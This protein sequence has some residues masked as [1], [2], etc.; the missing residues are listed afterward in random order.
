MTGFVGPYFLLERLGE[1]DAGPVFKARHPK[2]DRLVALRIVRQ[3]LL[4]DAD[5]INRFYR[6]TQVLSHLDH[7]NIVRAYDAGPVPPAEGQY[8]VGGNPPAASH[9][10]AEEFV[11][12]TDLERRVRTD[13]PLPVLLACAYVRQAALGLQH[14]YERGLVHGRIKP[15]NLIVDRDEGIIKVAGLGL[16]QL[17]LPGTNAATSGTAG[18]QAP[19]LALRPADI[20][21]DIYSLGCVLHYLLTGQPPFPDSSLTQGPAEAPLL[22]RWPA[23]APPG[24]AAVAAKMLA[25]RPEDR[26]QIPQ[27]VAD[28]LAEF[29]EP[30]RGLVIVPSA[31]E[32]APVSWQWLL[33]VVLGG[34]FL[35]G[36]SLLYFHRGPAGTGEPSPAERSRPRQ[37]IVFWDDLQH[38]R[39]PPTERDRLPAEVVAVLSHKD[40]PEVTGMAISPSG[41]RLAT[42]ARNTITFWEP[43]TANHWSIQASR[44]VHD[45][46]FAPDGLTLATLQV[47]EEKA[48]VVLYD[49]ASRQEQ[50]T[51]AET[52]PCRFEESLPLEYSPDGAVLVTGGIDGKVTVWDATTGTVR[53]RLAGHSAA[54]RALTFTVDGATL[55]SGSSDHTIK[56]KNLK[57]PNDRR[58]ITTSAEAVAVATSIDGRLAYALNDSTIRFWNVV[59]GKEPLVLSEP[60]VASIVF[61]ADGKRLASLSLQRVVLWDAT[62]GERVWQWSLPTDGNS[63]SL[64]L[65]PDGRHLAVACG[66]AVYIIRLPAGRA[67]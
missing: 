67:P 27:D 20:R 39:M 43:S 51:F 35:L 61:T 65:A 16:A 2:M 14:A 29:L 55:V 28:Q 23:D 45:L 64:A 58:T 36:G 41:G 34:A 30:N 40:Q 15:R 8:Q 6:E 46:R 22:D 1:G 37:P 31:S 38:D 60:A 59:K 10:L 49:V 53:F 13:G 4:A 21:T 9:F 62:S 66:A 63:G 54:V 48:V 33:I 50:L 18:Y 57:D 12:G 47:K 25:R 26:Y 3:E 56:L 32:P 19:E 5:I 52:Q 17:R 44:S 11:E 7:P 42:C 24:L